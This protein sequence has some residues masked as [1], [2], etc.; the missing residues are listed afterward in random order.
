MAAGGGDRHSGNDEVVVR[1][2]PFSRATAVTDGAP[3]RLISTFQC[4]AAHLWR[5]VTQARG[6]TGDETET[7]KISVDGRSRMH[8]PPVPEGYTGKVVPNPKP[9]NHVVELVSRAVARVDD[10]YFQS[11][12][13]FASSGAVEEERLVL[14]AD[15]TK[16]V[17]C[18]DVEVYRQMGITLYDLDFVTGRQFLYLPSYLPEKVLVFILPSASG[19]GSIDVQ[20]CRAMD[21][22]KN[23]CYSFTEAD[24]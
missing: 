15:P 19:D 17:H 5:C 14:T 9:L 10:G 16:T 12:I 6:L 2:V 13:D 21:V 8:H 20:V 1:M 18:P 3:G 24:A 11:F 7:L 23:W 22:F 4:I